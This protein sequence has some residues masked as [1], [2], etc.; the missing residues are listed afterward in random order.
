[1]GISA[2]IVGLPNVGKSTIFNALCSGKAAA[3]NYPFCT[4]DSNKGIVAVPDDR[5]KRITTFLETQKVVPAFLELVDIAGLVKGASKG[6]GLG[7]QFL[8]HIKNV[9]AIVQVVRCFENDDIVHVDGSVDPV[10]DVE[11]VNLELILKDLETV[12]RNI[13][14]MAK[15]AKSGEKEAKAQLALYEEV[16][17]VLSE[18]KRVRTAFT[19]D[20]LLKLRE[21]H[22]LTAKDV[23]Y[24]A[25]IDEDA[26]EQDNS[27]V[28][29]LRDLA[30]AEGAQY[31]KLCG[32]IE[33]EIAELPEEDRTEFLESLGLTESG[34][35]VLAHKIYRLLGLQTFFTSTPKESRAWTIKVGTTAAP[36]AGVIHTDFEKGFIKAE[37]FTLE[38]LEKYRTDP[39]LRA[40][41]KVRQEG[42]DYVVQDGDIIFFKFNV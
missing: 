16:R 38:D 6:E 8:G 29:A 14:R 30:G 20:S 2:G 21:L 10:R 22:L 9:N 3:E 37:V 27:H 4:I 5:L 39:A 18:G 31:M 12:E 32:K 1:M 35:S 42:H 41:G 7:N 17:D 19:D 24:V 23:L 13:E 36:A 26:I 40:A 11:T 33:A 15:I 34:L 28:S 25:N